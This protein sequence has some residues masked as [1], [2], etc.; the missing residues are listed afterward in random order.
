MATLQ[1]LEK[2]TEEFFRMHWF[3][4]SKSTTPHIPKP[5]WSEKW[6]FIGELP[7]NSMKGCYSWLNQDNEVIY[8]G[9][10]LSKENALGSRISNYWTYNDRIENDKRVYSPTNNLLQNGV[11][12]IITLPFKEQEYLVAALEIYLIQT[13]QPRLNIIHR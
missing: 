5:E 12:S 9:S 3:I 10:A 1:E 8:I 2:Q 11:S 4:D 6:L 7:N 13:L